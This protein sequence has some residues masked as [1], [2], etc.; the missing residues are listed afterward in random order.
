MFRQ[1]SM[2][3]NLINSTMIL[4]SA[5]FA[6]YI[7]CGTFVA[8]AP[9]I[10]TALVI[11]LALTFIT[12]KKLRGANLIT[13]A[14]FSQLISHYFLGN[15]YMTMSAPNCGMGSTTMTMQ[16]GNHM[17]SLLMLCTHILAGFASCVFIKKNEAFWEFAGFVCLRIFNIDIS[18][19][20]IEIKDVFKER[21]R[22]FLTF[23]TYLPSYLKSASSRLTAPP[24]F[25]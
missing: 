8:L 6:H 20:Y 12:S 13:L 14:I 15:S 24:L 19:I 7:A 11:I 18:I 22:L 3:K 21:V 4:T 2:G 1:E 5:V 23:I 25:A 9:F 10:G 16:M 17:N